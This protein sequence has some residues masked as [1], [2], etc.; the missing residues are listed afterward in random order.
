MQVRLKRLTTYGGNPYYA[1]LY[2]EKEL[3]EIILKDSDLID[4]LDEKPAITTPTYNQSLKE[5]KVAIGSTV[6]SQQKSGYNPPPPKIIDPNAVDK[7]KKININKATIDE[8]AGIDEITVT[9][10]KKIVEERKNKGFVDLADLNQRISLKGGKSWESK[11]D[12]IT[13][14]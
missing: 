8:L 2:D 3:P 14:S 7:T 10:A 9:L 6:S 1:G 12:L 13:F 11:K 4:R 5:Q